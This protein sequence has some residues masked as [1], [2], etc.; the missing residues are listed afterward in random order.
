MLAS[1]IASLMIAQPPQP[2]EPRLWFMFFLK[3]DGKRP[4]DPK[5]LAEMQADHIKNLQTQ[6]AAGHLLAAGPLTDPTQLRRGITV[7]YAKDR[8]EVESFFR[9]D[10][11]VKAGIMTVTAVAWEPGRVRFNADYDKKAMDEYE[12]LIT[13]QPLLRATR[14]ALRNF[15]VGGRTEFSASEKYPFS[16][17]VWISRK[18]DHDK[19]VA[20][21]DET[22]APKEIIPLWMAKNILKPKD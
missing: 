6:G 19:L 16:G 15:A 4:S 11:F 14:Y 2:A 1:F 13:T 9:T 17:E 22:L 10:A 18:A 3:G 12:L 8:A 20:A 7:A 21:M 5:E